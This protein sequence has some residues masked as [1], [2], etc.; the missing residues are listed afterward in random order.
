MPFVTRPDGAKIHYETFG[1]GHPLLLIAPGGVNSEIT[2]WK[3]SRINPIK[4]F[5]D[6]FMVIGMD[7]RHAG[8]SWDAPLSYGY[9]LSVGDQLAVLD[10]LDARR[11]HVWG[12]C[13]G[14]AHVMRIIHDAPGRISAGVGQDPVG[15]DHT[16][17][18]DTFYAMFKPAIETARE[19]GMQAVVQ[20]ALSNP[21]FMANNAAGPFARRIVA[22]SAF[23]QRLLSMSVD[24]YVGIVQRFQDGMWPHRPPYFTVDEAW[25]PKCSTPLLILPGNDRFHPTSVAHAI[26][27]RVQRGRC[28]DVDCRSDEKRPE[29]V[30]AIRSFLLEHAR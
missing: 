13:I 6:E 19:D 5:S 25:L 22:D 17:S 18:M 12:G 9:D 28:L 10:A 2:F 29:T 1:S 26:C 7:Q 4:E 8:E 23:R 24:E 27:K 15:L 21:L 16:N 14:V 3:R 11:A 30:R 20:A